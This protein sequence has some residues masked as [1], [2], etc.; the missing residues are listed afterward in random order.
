M[1]EDR[2]ASR[3]GHPALRFARQDAEVNTDFAVVSQDGETVALLIRHDQGSW[4]VDVDPAGGADVS[5]GSRWEVVMP[6]AERLWLESERL[7]RPEAD[8]TAMLTDDVVAWASMIILWRLS[9]R[10]PA[11]G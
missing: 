1:N 9:R 3:S 5:A 4:T 2:R 11:R 6:G 8:D 7:F 10:R